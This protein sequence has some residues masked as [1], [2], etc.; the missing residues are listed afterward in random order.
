MNTRFYFAFIL[1]LLIALV[2]L[3]LVSCGGLISNQVQIG[4]KNAKMNV[5]FGWIH[6][7]ADEPMGRATCSKATLTKS[8]GGLTSQI[9]VHVV[10]ST[11]AGLFFNSVELGYSPDKKIIAA[12]QI[13]NKKTL[14][15]KTISVQSKNAGSGM[16]YYAIVNDSATKTSNIYGVGDSGG[17]FLIITG[18]FND[19]TAKDVDF[20]TSKLDLY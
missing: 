17:C 5:P 4:D 15:P 9:T 20:F 19:T 1:L 12:Q 10:K 8:G 14:D 6:M 11:D 13:L 2:T 7:I 3:G 18:S 16:L